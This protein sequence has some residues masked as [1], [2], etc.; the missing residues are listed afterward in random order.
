MYLLFINV[1][2]IRKWQPTFFA[3]AFS[4]TEIMIEIET[5]IGTMGGDVIETVIEIVKEIET[6]IGTETVIAWELTTIETGTEKG[7]GM[8]GKGNVETDTGAGTGVVQGAG[9][10]EKETVKME[11]AVG[12]VMIVLVLEGMVKMLPNERNPSGRRKRERSLK[13]KMFQIR[14]IQRS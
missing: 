6:E 3:S 1:T 7:E 4:G 14:M 12:G 9:I 8:A 10:G 5:M 11:N 2:A 13:V